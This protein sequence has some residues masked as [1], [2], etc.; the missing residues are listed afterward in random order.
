MVSS[1]FTI[2]SALLVAG[3]VLG[4]TVVACAEAPFEAEAINAAPPNEPTPG[5][6]QGTKPADATPPA[7]ECTRGSKAAR[8]CGKCG[9]QEA[10]CNEDGSLGNYGPCKGEVT[11]GCIA[12][13][14]QTVPCGACGTKTEVCLPTCRLS[15]A[16]CTG[17]VAGGCVPGTVKVVPGGGCAVGEVRTQ[18]CT[19]T[20]GFGPISA[21]VANVDPTL[22]IR[23]VL[24][25]TTSMDVS[26]SPLTDQVAI[27]ESII[28]CPVVL[29][30]IERE[31]YA[32]VKLQNPFP[33]NATVSV[34][35]SRA[36]GAVS[37]PLT[38]AAWYARPTRPT[39]AAERAACTD[40]PSDGCYQTPCTSRSSYAGFIEDSD[41]RR[42][43]IPANSA[44][45]LYV[46]GSLP[47]VT[48]AFK[49][50]ARTEML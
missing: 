19:A 37:D 36:T 23:N 5:S 21:C 4:S 25:A 18:T 30:P 2:T 11:D 6:N 22:A 8:I 32:W 15:T 28:Q 9:T 50:N 35:L 12:G 44:V 41:D 34:W 17:E 16:V 10:L 49:V 42:I 27:F 45:Y 3:S 43:R 1:R 39:T 29:D 26:L 46:G 33:Q 20:C 47:T 14:T 38:V 7:A 31:S 48:G 40:A 13:T 24:G